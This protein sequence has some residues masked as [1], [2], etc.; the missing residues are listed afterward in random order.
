VFKFLP[1]ILKNLNG[2]RVR[3]LMT[4]GGTAIL[5]LLFSF[6]S[7]IQEG[8][9][10]LTDPSKQDDRLIVFQAY[11]FCPSVSQLPYPAY[12]ELIQK[13]PGVKTV[14]PIKVV[15]N[16]C[17]ASL[18]TVVFHGVPPERLRE[19]RELTFLE[20]GWEAFI[21]RR[22]GGAIVGRKIAERRGIVV[23]KPFTIAGVTVNVEGI[24]ASAE[25]AEENLIYTHLPFLLN[26]TPGH[27]QDLYVTM[28]E[29]HATDPA[30]A[31]AVAKDIDA[32]IR[33]KY[34]VHTETRPRK[35]Y[36]RHAIADLVELIGFTRWLG[37]VCVG[38]VAVL[39][40]N[41]V[42]M[43]AQDRVKEHAVLQTIGY[44]GRRIFALML[45]ESVLVSV[46]GGLLGIL[47]CQLWL[48]VSPMTVATEG[49]SIDFLASPALAAW[50]LA[51]STLVGVVAGL[52]PAWQAGRADIVSSLRQA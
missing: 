26:Q 14:L 1:Y 36:Y 33:D 9:A 30:R 44:S 21:G 18:D 16:N 31:E 52:V 6:V 50:G 5:M 43:A 3:T 46:V 35:A 51:L 4:V 2:H 39:V 49:V 48:S 11:R 45:A 22:D 25:P 17:R 41:S 29:V 37:L 38:V 8:L 47:G 23:D 42:I 7:S 20:G 19:V 13:T 34:L 27:H 40:A 24:F 10:Q 12:E 28:Y 15:V 32:Q